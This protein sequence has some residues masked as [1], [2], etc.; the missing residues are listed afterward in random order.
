MNVN[1]MFLPKI[2]LLTQK[3]VLKNLLFQTF[4]HS[5]FF[6]GFCTDIWDTLLFYYKHKAY[7]YT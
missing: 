3:N 1:T 5:N 6:L 7:K 2:K 4:Y